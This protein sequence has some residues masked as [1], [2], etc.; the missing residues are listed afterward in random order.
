MARKLTSLFGL[1]V[2]FPGIPA[3]TLSNAQNLRNLGGNNEFLLQR[4]NKSLQNSLEQGIL[5]YTQMSAACERG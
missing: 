4:K 2:E 5:S 1:E 3:R